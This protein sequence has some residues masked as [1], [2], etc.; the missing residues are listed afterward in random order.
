MRA[1][2]FLRQRKALSVSGWLLSKM[3][4]PRRWTAF[5]ASG[6]SVRLKACLIFAGE[7]TCV[8]V[9]SVSLNLLFREGLS[10]PCQGTGHSCSLCLMKPSRQPPNGARNAMIYKF[11]CL[12]LSR[13]LIG[14]LIIP[15]SLS[16]QQGS[17]LIWSVSC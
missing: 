7:W 17:S 8:P 4:E 15:K 5:F 16:L 14:I 2:Y 12:I 9:T 6:R 10:T 3:W 13:R 11:S 1:G